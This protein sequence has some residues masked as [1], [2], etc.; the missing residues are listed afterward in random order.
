MAS[1]QYTNMRWKTR[2]LVISACQI[3]WREVVLLLGPRSFPF[4]CTD[5]F[6][7]LLNFR[8]T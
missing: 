6:A 4:S 1:D 2:L 7:V 8:D 5:L 3:F